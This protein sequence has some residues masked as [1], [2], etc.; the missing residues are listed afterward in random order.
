M[1]KK[2]KYPEG[3]KKIA[4]KHTIK[5]GPVYASLLPKAT[6]KALS[7]GSIILSGDE[8]KNVPE[9]SSKQET[10]H[11][12][13]SPF[14]FRQPPLRLPGAVECNDFVFQLQLSEKMIKYIFEFYHK[15]TENVEF[16][17]Q[18]LQMRISYSKNREVI[19]TSTGILSAISYF[20]EDFT[21]KNLEITF[22][23]DYFT[24]IE[25]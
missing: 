14:N 7:I 22:K 2:E 3:K 25:L 20:E 17:K 8:I 6:V 13:I 10:I 19:V 21:G 23:P 9:L 16:K 12:E 15:M 4:K 5:S 18:D 1:K 24:I 11:Y